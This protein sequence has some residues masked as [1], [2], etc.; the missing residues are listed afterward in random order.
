MQG[1]N[2]DTRHTCQSQDPLYVL[3]PVLLQEPFS[4]LDEVTSAHL[5]LQSKHVEGRD[6]PQGSLTA[7]RAWVMHVC[8]WCSGCVRLEAKTEAAPTRRHIRT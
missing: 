1:S 6:H 3:G 2:E 7:D 5:L 8:S 4:D